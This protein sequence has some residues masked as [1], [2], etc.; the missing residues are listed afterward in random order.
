MPALVIFG[1]IVFD[2]V[3]PIFPSESLL[4]TASNLAAQ[5]GSPIELWRVILA[6]ALGAIVGDSLRYWLDGRPG[7]QGQRELQGGAGP[8]GLVRHQFKARPDVVPLLF[9]EAGND[10]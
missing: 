9:R 10:E 8:R 5:S 3:I 1:F 7:R 4:T 6:G 2:A